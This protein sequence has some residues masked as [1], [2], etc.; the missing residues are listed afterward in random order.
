MQPLRVPTGQSDAGD[1][2]EAASILEAARYILR[3]CIQPMGRGGVAEKFSELPTKSYT[4]VNSPGA[5]QAS[6]S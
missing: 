4:Y 2:A 1:D 5:L 3:G 6:G